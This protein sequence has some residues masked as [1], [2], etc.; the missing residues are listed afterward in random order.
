MRVNVKFANKN[1]FKLETSFK[2]N[3]KK[4]N[5]NNKCHMDSFKKSK[6]SIMILLEQRQNDNETVPEALTQ[7]SHIFSWLFILMFEWFY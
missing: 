7:S 1:N 3:E 6:S 2:A 4:K 5:C